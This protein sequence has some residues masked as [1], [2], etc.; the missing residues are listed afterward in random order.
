[1]HHLLSVIEINL[2]GKSLKIREYSFPTNLKFISTF[3]VSLSKEKKAYPSTGYPAVI[4][5]VGVNIKQFS[6]IRANILLI[7]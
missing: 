7:I 2:T 6:A 1:M 3:S 5:D 4:A